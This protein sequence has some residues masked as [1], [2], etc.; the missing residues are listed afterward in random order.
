M[1]ELSSLLYVG[2][3]PNL[4]SLCHSVKLPHSHQ[5]LQY[6]PSSFKSDQWLSKEGLG[7]LGLPKP[8]KE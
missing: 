5:T 2:N 7:T 1:V 8:L 4:G 6:V 3:G